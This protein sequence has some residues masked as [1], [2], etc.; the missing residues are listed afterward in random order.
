LVEDHGGGFV[1]SDCSCVV[2]SRVV[3]VC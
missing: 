3:V 1:V 2:F